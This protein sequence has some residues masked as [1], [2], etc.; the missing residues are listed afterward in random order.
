MKTI[1]N[2]ALRDKY[3]HLQSVGNK[4]AEINFL[5]HWKSFRIN[6][7]SIYFNKTASGGRPEDDVIIMFK[8][9]VLQQWHGLSDFEIEKQ[10][11]D[12]ISFR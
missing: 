5:I 11:I 6:F 8:M 7:E 3:K 9:L 4:L 12:R 1:T 2:F 10:C